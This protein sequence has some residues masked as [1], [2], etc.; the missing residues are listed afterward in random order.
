MTQTNKFGRELEADLVPEW[1]AKYLD[2]KVRA[3]IQPR[4]GRQHEQSS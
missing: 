1:R 3:S 4:R 2:Y